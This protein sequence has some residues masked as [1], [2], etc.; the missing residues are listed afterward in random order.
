MFQF[1]NHPTIL[2]LFLSLSLALS[3][4]ANNSDYACVRG[5]AGR[6]SA[7]RHDH[8]RQTHTDPDRGRQEPARTHLQP[9]PLRNTRLTHL[10]RVSWR[11]VRMDPAFCSEF[12][13]SDFDFMCCKLAPQLSFLDS[14]LIHVVLALCSSRTGTFARTKLRRSSISRR[15]SLNRSWAFSTAKLAQVSLTLNFR[16]AILLELQAAKHLL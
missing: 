7:L 13:G 10:V 8:H 15:R 14:I 12:Q 3:L 4:L 16:I 5:G 9:L 11:A 6:D 1:S 2:I